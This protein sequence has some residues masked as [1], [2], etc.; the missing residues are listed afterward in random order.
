MKKPP[1]ASSGGLVSVLMRYWSAFPHTAHRI[2]IFCLCFLWVR[3][4]R[5]C[6][7]YRVFLHIKAI[8]AEDVAVFH[9]D[10]ARQHRHMVFGGKCI[11]TLL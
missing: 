5:L 10:K 9:G 7:V 3:I 4:N 6:N 11:G 8:I 1:E 2:H